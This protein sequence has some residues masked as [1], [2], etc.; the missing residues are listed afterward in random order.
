STQARG[1][2][3]IEDDTVHKDTP[4]GLPRDNRRLPHVGLLDVDEADV[5][6]GLDTRALEG[7][8]GRNA[9]G[10]LVP[11]S[12]EGDELREVGVDADIAPEPVGTCEDVDLPDGQFGDDVA[13]EVAAGDRD[14]VDRAVPG[15]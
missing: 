5:G 14:V 1:D 11:E 12:I 8:H 2:V 7:G 6:A 9:R 4:D 3:V 10:Q 15:L 13:H